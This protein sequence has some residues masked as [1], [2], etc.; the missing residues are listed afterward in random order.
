MYRV[1]YGGVKKEDVEKLVTYVSSKAKLTDY[2]TDFIRNVMELMYGIARQSTISEYQPTPSTMATLSEYMTLDTELV[3]QVLV[4]RGLDEIW[5]KIWLTYIT[6]RPIKSDAKT[7]L[8]TYVKAFRYTVIDKKVL[9]DYIKELPNYGFTAKEIEFITKAIDL[10]EQIL[11]YKENR[12]EYTPTPSMLASMSEYITISEKLIQQVFTARKVP[13][14]WQAIWRQYIS[15]RPLVD[16]V[17]GLLTSYR[18]ALV[19]VVLSDDIKKKVEAY[20]NTIGFTQTEWDILALRTTLEELVNEARTAKSE[21]IPAPMTLASLCEYLPEAREFYSDVVQAKRI[22]KRWQELWARYIDIRPL[23]D[24]IKRYV[25]NAEALYVH[26]MTKKGD[27]EK[28]LKEASGYLGHTS[29]EIEFLMKVTEFERYRNA[30]SELIGSVQRLVELSEYSPKA[31]E[32]AL[33]KLY[34]MIDA[35]PLPDSDKIKLKAMWEEYI[36]NRPVKAEAKTYITQLIN[37]Y[38]EGL[39]DTSTF[40]KELSEMAKWG[41]SQ[42]ELM[43]YEAQASLR[44][45]RKLKIPVGE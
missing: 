42:D 24:D 45:A 25:S 37:M 15:I 17:R 10:E 31:S 20:A 28:I 27:F 8:S 26:F 30:W 11:E 23:V 21:Y 34:E 41:F 12:G 22:P 38:V 2:E 18:R 40:K 4:E 36:R 44:K 6:V 9:E 35:L 5:Q 13:E 19:Y 1:A 7:L 16:D 32:Y 39:M 33:G 29:K 43:F 14:E 3:K